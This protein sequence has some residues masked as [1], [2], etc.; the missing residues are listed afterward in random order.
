MELGGWLGL[1]MSCY[2]GHYQGHDQNKPSS[3][4]DGAIIP[5]CSALL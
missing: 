4:Q 1:L 3:M 2:L 5:G